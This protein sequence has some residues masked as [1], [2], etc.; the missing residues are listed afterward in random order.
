MCP[1]AI[2]EAGCA[3]CG[4][5]KP[6]Q[7]MSRLKS[8]KNFL[9]ILEAP[10]VT[11]IERRKDTNIKEYT[12][13]VLDY[14][15]S[16]IC[17]TC[18]KDIRK[19]KVPRLALANN[20]WLG[21]VPD[22]LKKLRFVEKILIS[23]VRHTCAFVK[24]ASGMRK[25]KANVVAFESPIPKIYSVLPPPREDLDEVLAILFTGPSKPTSEDFSRTPF[26]VRRNAVI[27]ALEWLKLNH[28]D[29]AKIE[30]SREHMDQYDEDMPPVS[31]EYRESVTNKVPE[32][33]SVFDQEEEEGTEKGDCAFV[34]HVLTGETL[35][36]MSPNAIKFLALRHLNNNGKIL[37]VGHSDRLESMWNNP[38]LYPQMF[39]W[40][41]PYGLGGV[42]ASNISH[43]EHKRHL[44]MYH[45][46]RFQIDINFPF[47]AFSHE[48]MKA[49]TTQSL[50]LVDQTRFV[51]IS[52]RLM[53][54]NWSA[55]DDLM[56]RLEAGEH[57]AP[58][59]D[60]EKLC[61]QVIKD[62]DTVSG[63][64]HGS[65]VSDVTGSASSRKPAQA[66]PG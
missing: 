55:L 40:L 49:N 17:D 62:L 14:A 18:R 22:E 27:A 1:K 63:K 21:K 59:T 56:K 64:M 20:L 24:V 16:Q 37:A 32:G 33:T 41:F 61:F 36:S 10:G 2:E 25:M 6:L 30:I 39:P 60:A 28:A 44:L 26:L 53:N 65:T 23:R 31:I 34:V 38:Q 3:V 42:G 12:G 47:V 51:D 4:E 57:V 48:Q 8:V 52:Q 7:K 13:P 66:E 5:L 46:K 15:C 29:Y 58:K 50:L 19:G 35:N 54:I 45:D 9:G 11:R 43:K